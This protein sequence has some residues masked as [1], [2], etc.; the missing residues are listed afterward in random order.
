MSVNIF[1]FNH[2]TFYLLKFSYNYKW[3]TF[4]HQISE[5]HRILIKIFDTYNDIKTFL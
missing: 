2:N 4:L 3:E 5:N 1:N